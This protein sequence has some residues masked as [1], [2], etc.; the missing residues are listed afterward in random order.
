MTAPHHAARRSPRP[1]SWRC[2]AR[3]ALTAAVVL[4]VAGATGCASR[5]R[6]PAGPGGVLPPAVTPPGATSPAATPAPLPELVPRGLPDDIVE[7]AQR[8]A[9]TP[10]R[11]GG[12]DPTGFDCSGFVQYVFAKHGV[13]LPRSVVSLA[14]VGEAVATDDIRTADLL[15]FSTTGPGPTHVAIALGDGR[16]VHAP[17]G[18]GMVRIENLSGSYWPMRFIEARRVVS[19]R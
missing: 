11:N 3:L 8:F 12:T 17:S 16:F 7:Y 13:R 10:Y 14:R 9:G 1:P 15:F 2:H 6:P 4:T 5:S 18:R 19:V